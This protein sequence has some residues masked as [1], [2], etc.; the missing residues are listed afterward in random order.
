MQRADVRMIEGSQ[1]TCFV[2]EALGELLLGKLE[3]DDPV[4]PRVASLIHL[5]HATRTDGCDDLIRTKLCPRGKAIE[6][7]VPAANSNR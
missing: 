3:S 1:R 6:V 7:I 4:E 5:T 2:L